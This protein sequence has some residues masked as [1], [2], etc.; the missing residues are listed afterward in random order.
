MPK[1]R[2]SGFGDSCSKFNR[3]HNEQEMC[4]F[5]CA[6]STDL[7]E[8]NCI[9]GPGNGPSGRKIGINIIWGV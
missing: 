5:I 1:N 9:R 8:K 6:K 3:N 4:P 2:F 7:A